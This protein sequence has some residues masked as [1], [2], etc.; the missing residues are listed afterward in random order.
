MI[1]NGRASTCDCLNNQG[2]AQY[3][4]VYG[5][6]KKYQKVGDRVPYHVWR[7]YVHVASAF[8]LSH[9]YRALLRWAP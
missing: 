4:P 2:P 1:Y 6:I 7:R 5:W 3:L 9:H 8:P